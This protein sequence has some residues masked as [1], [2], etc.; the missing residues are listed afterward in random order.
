MSA[1]ARP[2]EEDGQV[3]GAPTGPT[4]VRAD[5]SQPPLVAHIIYRLGVGGLENGLVN[6]INHM[7]PSRYRHVILC[8]KGHDAFSERIR[9]PGVDLIDLAKRD[10]KDV[11]VYWRAWGQLRRLKPDIVHLRNLGTIDF[12]WVARLAGVASVIQGEHGWDTLDLYGERLKYRLLRKAC[13]P[14]ISRYITV[15]TD[16]EQWLVDR[17]GVQPALVSHVC[18]GVDVQRFSPHWSG[19]R[20]GERP[21]QKG[22]MFGWVGRMAEVKA[23]LA[24]LEAFALL[25]RRRPAA[26]LRLLMVGD[27]L[28]MPAVRDHAEKSGL[29]GLLL[30]PGKQDDVAEWLHAM[31]VF[32][33]PSLNEGI[34]NTLLEAMASG[35]PVVATRVGGNPE[36]VAHGETGTLVRPGRVE[37][38]AAAMQ[39]YVD[40]PALIARHGQAGRRRA[41]QRFSLGAMVAGYL[42]VYDQLMA[43]NRWR[44]HPG[45]G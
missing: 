45:K 39:A 24:L 11:A 19:A 8:L 30:L 33:L 27:G 12:C 28:L 22:V 23:P 25:V 21:A 41:E 32:V 7:P 44:V 13:R 1:R 16:L 2:P 37:A 6:L 20:A 14:A 34:S 36:L 15:S 17:I 26:N 9:A 29:R 38:L 3:P 40:Q 4:Q 10:G 42:S 31:D 5:G 43:A 18:N 35:L